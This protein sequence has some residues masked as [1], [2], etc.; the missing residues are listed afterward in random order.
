MLGSAQHLDSKQE[1]VPPSVQGGSGVRTTGSLN[2]AKSSKFGEPAWGSLTTP[3]VALACSSCATSAGD[4][5][6]LFD[7]SCATMPATCGAAMLVPLIMATAVS[8]DTPSDM[9][10]EP[11]AKRSTQA[12]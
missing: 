4:S 10:L 8:D 7:S 5:K 9:M 3:G 6:G 2:K 11:G 1:P 12:P